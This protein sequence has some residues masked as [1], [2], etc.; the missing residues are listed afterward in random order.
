MYE[1]PLLYV[2]HLQPQSIFLEQESTSVYELDARPP[3]V[4]RQLTFLKA[5]NRYVTLSLVNGERIFGTVT[6]LEEDNAWI[7]T[8][9]GVI[10]IALNTIRY[11]R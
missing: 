10:C 11:V 5:Q 4:V 3:L 7:M 6:R 9:A 2:R 1:E 8:D